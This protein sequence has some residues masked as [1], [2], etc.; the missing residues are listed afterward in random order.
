MFSFAS[1]IFRCHESP[2]KRGIVS[3]LGRGSDREILLG[4]DIKCK[5]FP[6]ITNL[7]VIAIP[8]LCPTPEPDSDRS[9]SEFAAG[10]VLWWSSVSC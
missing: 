10:L 4:E 7:T 9:P 8:F 1:F 5:S 2:V 3:L 6:I